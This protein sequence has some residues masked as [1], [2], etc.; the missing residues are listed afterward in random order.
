MVSYWLPGSF[1]TSRVVVVGIMT[2]LVIVPLSMFKSVFASVPHSI[3]I[4][5]IS[6]CVCVCVCVCV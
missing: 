3:E 1:L 2:V 6:V 4:R 5:V